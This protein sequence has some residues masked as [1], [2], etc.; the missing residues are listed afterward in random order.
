MPDRDYEDRNDRYDDDVRGRRDYDRDDR[1]RDY[2]D[3]DDRPRRGRRPPRSDNSCL[4]IGLGIGCVVVL[5]CGGLFAVGLYWG[6]NAFKQL[7]EAI[8]AADRFLAQL[9]HNQVTEAYELTSRE[10][11]ARNTPEQFEEFIKEYKI[12]THHASRQ[13]GG[14]NI[15]QNNAKTQAI[16]HM[17]LKSPD[18]ALTCTLTLVQEDGEWKVDKL[19]VP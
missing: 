19:T 14:A 16:I 4:F 12:F 7:P 17:T 13:T 9:Q 5:G 15:F 6:M 18:N 1:E 3:R 10:Y 8:D 2:D 11:R